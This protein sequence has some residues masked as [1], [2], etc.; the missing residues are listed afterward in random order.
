MDESML[1]ARSLTTVGLLVALGAMPSISAGPGSA[2][3]QAAHAA[4]GDPMVVTSDTPEYCLQLLD[5]VSELVRL[6]ATP[7]PREV[8]DL[9]TEGHRMCEHGQTRGGIMRLRS[10]LVIMEKGDG[11]AYR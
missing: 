7:I 8:T 1:P 6:S 4:Q 2:L 9:T 5:R 10:A 11:T 3:A